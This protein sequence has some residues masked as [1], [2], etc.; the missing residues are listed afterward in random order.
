MLSLIVGYANV[1]GTGKPV[2]KFRMEIG[3]L[4]ILNEVWFMIEFIC[5]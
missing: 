3:A 4:R 5:V 1:L 2:K